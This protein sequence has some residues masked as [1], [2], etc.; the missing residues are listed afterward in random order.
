MT[1]GEIMKGLEVK[2]REL[3]LKNDEYVELA[4]T[5]AQSERDYNVAVAER[6]LKFKEQGQPATLIPSLVRGNKLVAELKFN[7]EVSQAV[8]KA[9]LQKIKTLMSQIDTYR[10]L[11]S[12]L[13]AELTSNVP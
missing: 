6:T 12:W 10:S 2:N 5:R 3:T 11:L 4:E 13:K 9:C 7:F 1:P 8:E